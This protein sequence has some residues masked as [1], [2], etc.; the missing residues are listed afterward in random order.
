M[1]T[2]Y[3]ALFS[4]AALGALTITTVG[5]Q[6]APPSPSA[7]PSATASASTTP[8]PSPSTSATASPAAPSHTAAPK[9]SHGKSAINRFKGKLKKLVS[10]RLSMG[11]IH[12]AMT[13]QRQEADKLRK[14]KTIPFSKLRIVRVSGLHVS[15]A[16]SLEFVAQTTLPSSNG[17]NSP[18]QYLQYVLANINVSNAL[19][20]TLNNSTVNVLVPLTDVLN[21]D[22]LAL[23]QVVGVYVNSAGLVYTI[24]G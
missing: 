22:N 13:H 2:I 21:N 7:A 6:T 9:R 20:N 3:R 24:A 12:F 10:T 11:M 15:Q 1:Q 16:E 8:A 18:I 4:V 14:M 5:A 23:G 19:N 17:S